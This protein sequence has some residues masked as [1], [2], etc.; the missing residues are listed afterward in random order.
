MMLDNIIDTLRQDGGISDFIVTERVKDGLEWYLVRAELDT[1]RHV[2]TTLY[3]VTLY[4]DSGQGQDRKRGECSFVVHPGTAADELRSTIT[5]AMRTAVSMKNPWF[6][7]PV[8]DATSPEIPFSNFSLTEHAEAMEQLRRVFY[9]YD[10]LDGATINSL[11]I[12]LSHVTTRIINSQ[13]V[14]VSWQSWNGYTEYVVNA[15]T[16]GRDE[17]ELY[18][19]IRF[20]D[21]DESRLAN[22]VRRQLSAARDRLTAEPTPPCGGLPLVLSGELAAQIY[23]Y[24]FE[25]TQADAVWDKRSNF[26][27]GDDVSAGPPVDTASGDTVLTPAVS[28]IRHDGDSIDLRAVPILPGSPLGGPYDTSGYTLHSVP[29]IEHDKVT[30]LVASTRYAHYLRLPAT[31]TLQLFELAGGRH[32]QATLRSSDHLEVLSFSD[33][34]VDGTTGDFGGEIRLAYLV[35]G[36]CRSAVSGGS[37]TGNLVHN[38]GRIL[39][40]SELR[41]TAT[42]SAPVCCLL[43]IVS[44]SAAA[45]GTATGAPAATGT[46]RSS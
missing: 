37:V 11:E 12:F 3:D 25:N 14:D 20:S 21:L 15:G 2:E 16:R 36:A 22:A 26:G 19:N 13:G 30:G 42:A 35:R 5:R 46:D 6:P 34:F 7:L 40:S 23:A 45:A 10:G 24:W 29:L 8:P 31:G 33:F 28:T 27:L 18:D 17:V 1:V 38:R 43:P 9:R 39:L 44:I 41:T 32:S 4:V